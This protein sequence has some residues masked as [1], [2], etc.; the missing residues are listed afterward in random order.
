MVFS[1]IT[2]NHK[3]GLFYQQT[4]LVIFR[5]LSLKGELK[6]ISMGTVFSC[7]MVYKKNEGGDCEAR[8]GV[9]CRSRTNV[10]AVGVK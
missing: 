8:A 6:N 3:F 9:G 10:K 1:L 5:E 2:V 4:V 7:S